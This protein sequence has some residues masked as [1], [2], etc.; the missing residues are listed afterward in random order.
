[1]DFCETPKQAGLYQPRTP[2]TAIDETILLNLA[3]AGTLSTE[4]S[5]ATGSPQLL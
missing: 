1:M 3:F 2:E 4:V 5:T